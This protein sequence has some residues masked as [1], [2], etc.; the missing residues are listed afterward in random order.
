[1]PGTR[2]A[3]SEGALECVAAQSAGYAA[4]GATA[5]ER[6]QFPILQNEIVDDFSWVLGS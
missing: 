4:L 5:Q 6:R 1:M 2:R 3:D